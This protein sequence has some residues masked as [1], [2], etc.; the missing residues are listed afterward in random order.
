MMCLDIKLDHCRNYLHK[1][2][3]I[4]M[5]TNV[6]FAL[7]LLLIFSC[8]V[9]PPVM[10]MSIAG[11]EKSIETNPNDTLSDALIKAYRSHIADNPSDS[12]LNSKYLYRAAGLFAKKNQFAN[13]AQMLL[14]GV[15]NYPTASNTPTSLHLLADLYSNKLRMPDLGNDLYNGLAANYPNYPAIDKI[16]ATMKAPQTPLAD[17]INSLISTMYNEKTHFLDRNKATGYINACE[18]YAISNPSDEKAPEFLFKAAETSRTIKNYP[19]ALEIYDWIYNS[20]GSYSKSGQA[21]FLKAFTL[22]ND[23]KKYDLARPVYEAFLAK[24][25]DDVFAKDTKFLLENL[26]KSDNEIINNFGK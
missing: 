20:F 25:P 5:K 26:G 1:Y 7:V 18:V 17:R 22:D 8:K 11:L 19:K 12:E 10:D 24:H 4:Y 15:K 3:T 9:D 14:Q 6:F 23:M 21:L 2:Q 16:K 13:A